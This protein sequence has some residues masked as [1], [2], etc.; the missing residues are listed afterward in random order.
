MERLR[1][2][3]RI[4]HYLK[5]QEPEVLDVIKTNP[6]LEMYI[7][8]INHGLSLPEYYETLNRGMADIEEPNLIYNVGEGVFIH[9]F[10]GDKRTIYHPV[11]PELTKHVQES[12]EEVMKRLTILIS[13]DM[14]PKTSKEHIE[15]FDKL[16]DRI[17]PNSSN[18]FSKF[19][20]TM[21][22]VSPAVKE[23]IRYYFIRDKIGLGV[24]QPLILDTFIEDISCNGL[25]PIF[26]EHKIFKSLQ[27]T[28]EFANM[29]ALDRFVL[30]LTERSGRP[31]THS[32]PI[33]DAVL[34]DGSRLNAIYGRDLSKKG[35]NFTIRKVS[36]T[37][38]SISQLVSFRGL[39]AEIA[40]YIWMALDNGMSM[41]IVGETASGKTTLLNACLAFI[42]PTAKIVS[43]EDTPEVLPPHINW[44]R[45]VT[46]PASAGSAVDTFDLLKAG[47]RQRPNYIIIGEIRGAEGNTAFQAIQTGHP[48][49][50]TFHAG[51]VKSLINRLTGEPIN[52]PPH[53]IKFLDL[54]IIQNAV[55]TADGKLLRR[56]ISANELVGYSQRTGNYSFVELASWDAK[57]DTHNFLKSSH[58]LE[59]KIAPRRGI[60]RKDIK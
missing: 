50:S 24:L 39:T 43:I 4:K 5:E 57:T 36:E 54:A 58:I 13:S 7:G 38:L 23:R 49:I 16:L 22:G 27:S 44:A 25:T 59:N 3:Q 12:I 60:K 52:I 28:I 46:R 1:K 31:A 55:H 15:L 26:I 14:A 18:M 40:A 30:S 29:A 32:A 37:P 33:V 35:S 10:P 45:E 42:H 21:K 11:E 53:F 34:P 8:N 20:P 2:K 56:L 19:L 6:H 9:V 17:I 48:V 41:F 47:L 51:T